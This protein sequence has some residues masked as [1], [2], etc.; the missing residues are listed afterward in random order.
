MKRKKWS[1]YPRFVYVGD[2]K[3]DEYGPYHC[4][5]VMWIKTAKGLFKGRNPGIK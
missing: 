5:K 4:F 3:V 1:T 2:R